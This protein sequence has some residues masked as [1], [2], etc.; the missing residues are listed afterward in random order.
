MKKNRHSKTQKLLKSMGKRKRKR[1]NSYENS[2]SVRIKTKE[3]AASPNFGAG[4][5][6]QTKKGNRGTG[7]YTLKFEAGKRR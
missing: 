1:K 5:N 2:V 7:K 6:H 3:A 4:S